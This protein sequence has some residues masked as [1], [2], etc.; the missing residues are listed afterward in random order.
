MKGS[1]V[2]GRRKRKMRAEA[3]FKGKGNPVIILDAYLGNLT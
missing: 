2:V 3:R 1:T